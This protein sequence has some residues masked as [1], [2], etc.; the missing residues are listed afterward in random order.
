MDKK[1]TETKKRWK[2]E[3]NNS[4]EYM[5]SAYVH[6]N[7]IGEVS[8]VVYLSYLYKEVMGLSLPFHKS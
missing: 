2:D 8:P 3:L 6:E 1:I 7:L 4:H 5:I